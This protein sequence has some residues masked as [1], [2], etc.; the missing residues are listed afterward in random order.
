M[1]LS[2][3]PDWA[4]VRAGELQSLAT[5]LRGGVTRRNW[6]KATGLGTIGAAAAAGAGI[7]T[8]LFFFQDYSYAGVTCSEVDEHVDELVNP[9]CSPKDVAKYRVH[10]RACPRCSKKY[11]QHC[12]ERC[13]QPPKPSPPQ[14]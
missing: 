12:R 9:R 7:A 6:L 11:K 2:Q 4:P 3:S 14:P 1:T 10:I 13:G 8:W 5:R